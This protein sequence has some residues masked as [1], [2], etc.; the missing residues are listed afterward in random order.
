MAF[1]TSEAVSGGYVFGP[2]SV[3]ASD[4]AELPPEL[5]EPA[6]ACV[7]LPEPPPLL[8]EPLPLPELP[9]LEPPMRPPPLELAPELPP[10]DPLVLAL[11]EPLDVVPLDPFDP[12]DAGVPL[13]P[14]VKPP[15]SVG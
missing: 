12:L 15:L 7:P 6:S 10:L 14:P 5:L 3:D 4:E 11:L 8:L 9:L 2:V 13:L 1:D